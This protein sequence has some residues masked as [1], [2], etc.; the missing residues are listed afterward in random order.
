MT[1][2]VRSS[3][4]DVW[5]AFGC[6]A[7]AFLVACG[8][9]DGYSNQSSS[10]G[11]DAALPDQ[12][13]G[14]ATSDQDGLLHALCASGY[15][16]A[17]ATYSIAK[18]RFAFGSTPVPVDAGPLVRWTGSD[19]VVAIWDDGS[20]QALLDANALAMGLSGWRGDAEALDTYVIEYF[21][22]MGV[23]PCQIAGVGEAGGQYGIIPA[24]GDGG[25][26]VAVLPVTVELERGVS[27]VRVVESL[28]A[29]E[30]DSNDQTTHETFYW[31]EI[32]ADIVTEALAF[33]AQLAAPGGLTAYQA[34]LPGD[35][36]GGSVVIHH[37]VAATGHPFIAVAVYDIGNDL[38][39]DRNGNSVTATWE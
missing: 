20:E 18:S 30:F 13:A 39:F 1:P 34:K 2:T 17:D 4:N 23:E 5:L 35:A 3:L 10:T 26:F 7:V 31:P 28:A 21:E 32:P 19:G 8:G 36:Q 16:L 14:G 24:T 6:A 38:F 9:A 12:N 22:S 27:G 15:P 37:T 33:Q 25:T 11:G 29:A